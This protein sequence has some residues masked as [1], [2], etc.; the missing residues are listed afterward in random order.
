MTIL[1]KVVRA[2]SVALLAVTAGVLPAHAED[3]VWN[4]R[5][6][7]SSGWCHYCLGAD[8]G[9]NFACPCRI[10]DPIIIR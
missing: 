1:R 9:N 8:E 6:N 2:M 7:M 5:V 3:S 10:N 4:A